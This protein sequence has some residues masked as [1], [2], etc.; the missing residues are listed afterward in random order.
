MTGD[1]RLVYPGG[2][3]NGQLNRLVD[4]RFTDV[5]AL[6]NTSRA[7][8]LNLTAQLQKSFRN[9]FHFMGAYNF[10]RAEDVTSASSSI[11]RSSFT[12]NPVVGNAND[13][14]L[15]TS[16]NELR[17]RVIG[18]LVFAREYLN[19][20]GTSISLFYTGRSGVPFS[21]TYAGDLN[22]DGINGNDLI[23]VSRTQDEIVLIP[24]NANDTRTADQIWQQLDDYI[25]QDEYLNSRRGQF[26][27]RNGPRTPWSFQL[28]LAIRQDF[29]IKVAGKRNT[30]QLSFDILNFGNLLN[31]DW[32]VVQQFSRNQLI[33]FR[34]TEDG[35]VSGRPTFSF[36]NLETSF[37]DNL[38][39][40]SKWQ[41]QLGV[42]Y[43][44]N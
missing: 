18:N 21:Y 44:F 22:A 34:G 37:R 11:A 1:G 5:M 41:G 25:S 28:D 6:N 3:T 42:R 9:G 30:I 20:F 24:S 43:I 16:N 35:T 36:N 15:A 19:N 10:G 33:N 23:Y 39:L 8:Q 38:G 17:H 31:P 7:Y 12:G 13:L 32:G 4:G 2:S 14:V 40:V 29:F 27:E 26:A